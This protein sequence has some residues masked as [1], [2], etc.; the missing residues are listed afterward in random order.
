MQDASTHHRVSLI[1]EEMSDEV[2]RN[3]E[4][5]Q[6][7]CDEVAVEK[8]NNTSCFV[9]PNNDERRQLGIEN[10]DH[11]K[12][13]IFHELIMQYPPGARREDICREAAK[14]TAT[15]PRVR[16]SHEKRELEWIRRLKVQNQ[17]PVLL[18][19]GADHVHSFSDLAKRIGLTVTVLHADWHP[20]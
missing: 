10:V 14:R 11:V 18:V 5:T 2:L 17:F 12:P 4:E 1:A 13:E 7:I 15:D 16:V 3:Y 19:C 8:L 6:T 9:D 20:T